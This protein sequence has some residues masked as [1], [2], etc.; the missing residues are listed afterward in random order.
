MENDNGIYVH[1]P[2]C[3]GKCPYCGFYSVAS[4][5]G[6]RAYLDALR[7][8]IR[9]RAGYLP[10]R[11][12]STLYLGGGTPS[13]LSPGELEEI[14]EALE[15]EYTFAPSAERTIEVN[16]EDITR[17]H[18]AAW[19]SLGFNRLS[20]G[21]QSLSDDR[22]R[23]IHR[24]HTAR[25][26]IDGIRAA[27]IAG[28]DNTGADLILGLPGQT[29]DEAR[30]DLDQ[31]LELPLR[32]V[33]LYLLSIDPGTLFEVKARRGE[34]L[35]PGDDAQADLFTAACETLERAGFEHYE[36]SNFAC[37]GHYSR[38]NTAYWQ[39]KPYAGFGPAAHSHD[40]HSR[41]W[42]LPHLQRYA[43]A[44]RDGTPYFEREELTAIDRYNEYVMTSL[45]TTWGASLHALS[46]LHAPCYH[47]SRP[48]WD[49]LLSSGLLTRDG[50]RLRPT[51]RA[52]LISDS[53]F[54]D[55]FC[56]ND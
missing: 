3:R 33:S 2:F 42:N 14:V 7:E 5:A 26:A 43:R 56:P 13:T 38:H 6:K 35:L 52:W 12:A 24:R 55:L 4:L 22:L 17:E 45:R 36:I 16:P 46:T 10:A 48:A 34:L 53:L 11:A 31:L 44:L 19:R 15:R 18:L 30:R 47:R 40:G 1:V 37:D 23:S 8:E 54:P 51:P 28:F 49:R 20:I 21:V 50:D 29:P 25:Q 39:Q 9:A 27:A 41:Q 32:H